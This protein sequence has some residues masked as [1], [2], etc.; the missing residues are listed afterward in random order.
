MSAS[1]FSSS[2]APAL[3]GELKTPP[4]ALSVSAA[5]REFCRTTG[6]AVSRATFYR[7]VR[8][9]RI[10]TLWLWQRAYISKDAL[11]REIE[12]FSAGVGSD[13]DKQS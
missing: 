5:W 7:W 12:A 10:P 13:S 8:A 6:S 2:T 11:A 4:A 3:A 1:A 9:G